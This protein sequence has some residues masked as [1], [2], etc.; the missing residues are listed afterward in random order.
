MRISTRDALQDLVEQARR[1]NDL[2]FEDHLG[3]TGLGLSFSRIESG[4][5]EIEFDLPDD[6]K[7]DAT[8]LTLRMFDQRSEAFSFHRLPQ[9]AE[10][11]GLSEDFRQELR[12]SAQI[13]GHYLAGQ[14]ANIRPGFF[15][16]GT[17]PT[18]GEI[19]RT[20]IGGGLAHR[21]GP[22][23]ARY[24]RWTRDPFR[25]NMLHQVFARTIG[26]LI[27]LI[28]RIADLASVE[29]GRPSGDPPA[30]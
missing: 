4:G 21:R 27:P 7:R 8:L 18:R 29:L 16:P 28:N 30:A 6:E 3:E 1:L 17:C 20:V 14:P 23:R 24:D 15:E 11:E 10:D 5:W 9:L 13:Y 22:A 19:M 26:H 2:Q 25:R 12:S